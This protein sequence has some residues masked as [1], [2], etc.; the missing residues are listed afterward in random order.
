M[1]IKKDEDGFKLS[2]SGPKSWKDYWTKKTSLLTVL[3]EK[4][5][6]TRNKL[7]KRPCSLKNRFEDLKVF[8]S[9]MVKQEREWQDELTVASDGE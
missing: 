4:F 9:L 8:A 6:C 3:K 1:E 2:D 5:S 7:A